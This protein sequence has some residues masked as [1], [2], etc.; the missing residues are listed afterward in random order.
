MTRAVRCKRVSF[1]SL[2]S[3]HSKAAKTATSVSSVC[4]GRLRVVLSSSLGGELAHRVPGD[5]NKGDRCR[6]DERLQARIHHSEELRRS[7]PRAHGMLS[8]SPQT[9]WVAGRNTCR[10]FRLPAERE[11]PAPPTQGQRMP[12]SLRLYKKGPAHSFRISLS[13]FTHQRV[14]PS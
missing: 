13:F 9:P 10:N 6:A 5:R 1:R 4:E 3:T 8:Q 14:R 2:D 11:V 7:K 12:N